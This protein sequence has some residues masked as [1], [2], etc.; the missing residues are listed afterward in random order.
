VLLNRQFPHFPSEF[1]QL[2]MA[3]K[4]LSQLADVNFHPEIPPMKNMSKSTGKRGRPAKTKS[5]GS[6]QAAV[7]TSLHP[8]CTKCGSRTVQ[9]EQLDQ[10]LLAT[11]SL[12]CLICGHYSFIGKPVI[13]LLKRPNVVIPDSIKRSQT[14]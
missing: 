14:G 13:R 12:H 8:R 9:L 11:M 1:Q 4:L 3:R 5:N 6:A 10:E 7:S 2:M